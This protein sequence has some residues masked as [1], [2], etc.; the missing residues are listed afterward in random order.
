[1]AASSVL[2][3]AFGLWLVH[4]EHIGYGTG[5]VDGALA[6]F[7]GTAVLGMVGGQRP[8]C[9]RKLAEGGGD[10]EQ[11]RWMLNDPIARALNYASAVLVVAIVVLMV[12]K[13]GGPSG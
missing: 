5:W 1:M 8:K 10:P 11:T 2:V 9:A 12:F 4:L 7:A 13:P 6:L 3:L